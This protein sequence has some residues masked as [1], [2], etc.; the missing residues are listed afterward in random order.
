LWLRVVASHARRCARRKRPMNAFRQ[1]GQKRTYRERAQPARRKAK[2]F[3]EKKRDYVVRARNHKAK[4]AQLKALK[5]HAELKNDDEF[6][7][8]TGAHNW[9]TE[10]QKVFFSLC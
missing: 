2:G 7:F 1:I 9:K 3:L 6:Y 5:R 4:Q 10:E 8:V